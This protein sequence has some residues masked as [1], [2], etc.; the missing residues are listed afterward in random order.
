[1]VSAIKINPSIT[2]G[3]THSSIVGGRH[4]N[5]RYFTQE[6]AYQLA[7]MDE[8][9]YF[10]GASILTNKFVLTAAHCTFGYVLACLH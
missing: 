5:R 8:E 3:L 6:G 10:C 1:M 9:V 2:S 7:M 4:V